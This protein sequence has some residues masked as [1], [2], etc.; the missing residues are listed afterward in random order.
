MIIFALTLSIIS[1]APISP[2]L[3]FENT[4]DK[5]STVK[6]PYQL[7]SILLSKDMFEESALT[8]N[9][10]IEMISTNYNYANSSL[11]NKYLHW[12]TV[13]LKKGEIEK[14]ERKLL[15]A[16]KLDPSNKSIPLIMAKSSFPDLKKTTKYLFSYISTINFLNNKVFF[17][18]TLLLLFILFSFWIILSTLGAGIGFFISYIT[19][20]LQETINISGLWVIAI[21]FSMF[22]W[23]PMQIVFLILVAMSLLKMKKPDLVRCTTLLIL[24]PFLISYSY[25]ISDNFNPG[26]SIYKEFK[27]RLNPYKY[28]LDSPVTPYGYSIKGIQEAKKNNFSK[29]K[30]F[31]EKG[32]NVRRDVS[33]LANLCSVYYAEGDTARAL[34]MCENVLID[35]PQNEI[36]NIIIIQILYDRLNF[37]EAE[38]HMEK[39]G[40]RLTGI[41]NLELPIYG[42]PPERWLYKYIFVPR[43][44]LK[45]LSGKNQIIMIIIGICLV[46]MAFFKKE[47]EAYCPICKS[48]ML[49]G[50][51]KENTCLSCLKKLSLTKSKS[52]R[53][54]LKKRITTKAFKVDKITNILMSLIIPGSAHF[55]KNRKFEGIIISFFAALLLLILINSIFFQTE[56]SLQYKTHIGNNSFYVSVILFYSLLL[57]SSWRLKPYGNGR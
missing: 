13:D 55:Y 18:K 8:Q 35:D 47:K 43:G 45:H 17:V 6:E 12:G 22:V 19:K 49:K 40:V 5:A 57:F 56:I 14:G 3:P 2:E 24:L 48:I 29:A 7:D 39:T 27:T 4:L 36:A 10:L 53:E 42:Y 44:L 23:L 32:Y 11:A 26:S 33:Y 15:F 46:V 34:N 1:Q 51:N 50:K 20:W 52:I 9:K 54:R 41:S 21:L 30:D 25:V 31:F 38:A 16:G 37:D 28:Q